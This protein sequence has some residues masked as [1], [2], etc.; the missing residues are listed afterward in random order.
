[1][2]SPPL[3]GANANHRSRSVVR[4]HSGTLAQASD[5]V[6]RSSNQ[7]RARMTTALPLCTQLASATGVGPRNGAYPVHPTGVS[8]R[9]GNAITYVIAARLATNPGGERC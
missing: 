9:P 8:E 6:L 2:R 5:L 1:M 7:L 4:R 3:G